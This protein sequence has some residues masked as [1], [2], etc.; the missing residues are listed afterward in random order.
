MDHCF[1]LSRGRSGFVN[2][3]HLS[4][5]FGSS[6]FAI[7]PPLVFVIALKLKVSASTLQL[8]FVSSKLTKMK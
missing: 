6:D 3:H 2:D 7:L 5:F 8:P 1:V 4:Y